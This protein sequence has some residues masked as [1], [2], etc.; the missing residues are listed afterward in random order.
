MK[1]YSELLNRFE[2]VENLGGKAW[3]HAVIVDFLGCDKTIVD[4]TPHCT[5][6][7]QM[8]EMLIKHVLEIKSLTG[9]YR[10][11][12]NLSQL[13]DDLEVASVFKA[14]GNYKS[15]LDVI[16]ACADNYRYEFMLD[17]QA[18]W[19]SVEI[20]KPLIDELLEFL[21]DV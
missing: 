15:A 7:Q 17:C 11:T 12:H 21:G 10:R 19:R 3:E 20:T 4:C 13:L 9:S 1:N 8:L 5:N 18:Y 6:Y 14:K 2:N 16:K